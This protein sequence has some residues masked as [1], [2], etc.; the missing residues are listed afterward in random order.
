VTAKAKRKGER[1]GEQQR[2]RY[3]YMVFARSRVRARIYI[4]RKSRDVL[5][6]LPFACGAMKTY[7][8]QLPQGI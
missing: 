6:T 5:R 1:D 4:K 3:P 7:G 8:L 2:E